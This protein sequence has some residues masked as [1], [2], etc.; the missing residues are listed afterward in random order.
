[1]WEITSFN[2]KDF[3]YFLIQQVRKRLSGSS[4]ISVDE[5]ENIRLSINF[6][7]NHASSGQSIAERYEDGIKNLTLTIQETKVLYQ[8]IKTN[9]Q[10][11]GI[12]SIED[13][14]SALETFFSTYD[15][16]YSAHV[17]G[18]SFI[19]Y[20]LANPVDDIFYQGVDFIKQYLTSLS[21]ENEFIL[22]FPPK[23]IK[24]LLQIY[25]QR[26]KFD[27]R[28]DIN[29][30][31]QIV[32]IQWLAKRIS[33]SNSSSLV[34]TKPEAE[35]V[36][37]HIKKNRLSS[38]L[39]QFLDENS[40]HKKSSQQF[41]QRITNLDH[42]TSVYNVLLVEEPKT[43]ELVLHPAM[44]EANF[45]A[46]LERFNT[47]QNQNS[48]VNVLLE[49]LDS[50]YDLLDF[51]NQDIVSDAFC[52][53]LAEGIPFELGLGLLLVI[54]QYQEGM[55]T[56]W[57]EVMQVPPDDR[58]IDTIQHFIQRTSLHQKTIINA[59]FQQL[60]IGERDFS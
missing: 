56:S 10:S 34:V 21:I 15:L 58:I 57:E 42:V 39:K 11:Y 50:P 2:K 60:T 37:Q 48:Q 20:Q 53:K 3:Q 24:E 32:F 23:Q 38:D 1:M 16:E 43:Q 26:L 9:Y 28:K 29:N 17:S 54:N 14:L 31:Y 6:A 41:M 12:D 52:K 22:Q 45:N 44:S 51:L 19:D 13:T 27:Y 36:Y 33:G 30:L 35:Y 5:I 55:L 7:L 18:A 8:K 46:M 25:T 47:Q 4:V 40:Y 49:K 59:A